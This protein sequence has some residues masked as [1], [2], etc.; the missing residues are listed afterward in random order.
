MYSANLVSI[1]SDATLSEEI[2]KSTSREIQLVG[3]DEAEVR[4]GVVQH[5][6]SLVSGQPPPDLLSS[7]SRS[8]P[9]F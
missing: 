8:L 3:Q 9:D 7:Q 5:N 1:A 4:V 6:L 2:Q